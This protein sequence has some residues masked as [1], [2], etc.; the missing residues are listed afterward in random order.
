M[1][2]LKRRQVLLG[3]VSAVAAPSVARAQQLTLDFPSWQ[4]EEPGNREWLRA[5]I[6]SFERDNPGV[7]VNLF[8]IPFAQFVNQ[9]T[10]RFVGN[11]PPD[12]VH[13]PV[14][15]LASFASQG[16]L[17]PLD[18]FIAT[19]DVDR[20]WTPLRREM[21]WEGKTFGLL[22]MAYGSVLYYN[23]S[24]LA[25]ADVPVPRTPNEWLAAIERTTKRDRGVFGLAAV[26][27]DNPN[28]IVEI[29]TWVTGQGLD[30]LEGGRY[31]FRDPRIVAAFE[32]YRR[33]VRFAPAGQN[34]SMARQNFADGKAA[35]LRDGPWVW[36][37]LDR[38]PAA[39]RPAL[40]MARLPFEYVSGGT[41][42]GLHVAARTTGRKRE[43]VLRFMRL[44]ASPE[45]QE[46]F[47]I[48]TGAPAPRRG[49]LG[50]AAAER[51]PHLRLVNASALEAR[52]LFPT[53]PTV[54]DNYNEFAHEISQAAMRMQSTET[55][56]AE[57]L[58]NLQRRLERQIPVD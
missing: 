45:M 11:N 46:Q 34:T 25:E 50:E 5:L 12:I 42:H 31:R 21:E 7:R 10:T 48:V 23:E 33:S 20:T 49:A 17:S 6:A 41:S 14:R 4:A 19:T 47:T 18:D 44:A 39:L 32:Q 26:T 16:W 9:M 29:G 30:W 38:A 43:L 53:V 2:G 37:L 35:F 56:T 13:L 40:K 28:M 55:P 51:F 24:L 36:P 58:D 3:A 22:L 27:I 57:I 8:Q 52:N 15:N 54:R 1:I